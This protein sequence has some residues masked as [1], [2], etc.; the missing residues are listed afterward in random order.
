M[1]GRCWAIGHTSGH[2]VHRN[3]RRR[4]GSI[5][6]ATAHA[7]GAGRRTTALAMRE[8]RYERELRVRA[9]TGG[10]TRG[11][12]RGGVEA[13]MGWRKPGRRGSEGWTLSRGGYRRHRRR[14]HR[15]HSSPFPQTE[16]P[17]GSARR[18]HETPSRTRRRASAASW[19][20]SR[21]RSRVPRRSRTT[22]PA[23]HP[24]RHRRRPVYRQDPGG[25][26]RR[27]TLVSAVTEPPRRSCPQHQRRMRRTTRAPSAR[28]APGKRASREMARLPVGRTMICASSLPSSTSEETAVSLD[29]RTDRGN[30]SL[31]PGEMGSRVLGFCGCRV[32][33]QGS[34]VLRYEPQ[35]LEP[36]P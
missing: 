8:R 18:A 9:A 24:D 5:T 13:R 34:A 14:R 1:R 4:R 22:C 28:R 15:R 36:E 32:R 7:C 35:N 6:G 16:V 31:V 33:V 10:R 2:A 19:I 20:R 30:S 27:S 21:P 3:R 23:V 25:E 29:E 17:A 26:A 11:G 12:A